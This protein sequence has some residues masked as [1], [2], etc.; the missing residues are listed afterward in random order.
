MWN[1]NKV[2]LFKNKRK[3]KKETST[4]V[5][6]ETGEE[7]AKTKSH[8]SIVWTPYCNRV[9]VQSSRPI[10]RVRRLILQH[11]QQAVGSR[12]LQLSSLY[13]LKYHFFFMLAT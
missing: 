10:R 2:G 5:G 3:L 6:K 1:P 9:Q 11:K 13:M 4:S 12:R 7:E 8:I